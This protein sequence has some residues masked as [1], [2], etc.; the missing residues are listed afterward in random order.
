MI[1]KSKKHKNSIR[2]VPKV[3]KQKA[4]DLYEK[5]GLLNE[6]LLFSEGLLR[7]RFMREQILK[8]MDK[9]CDW[10]IRKFNKEDAKIQSRI[11]VHHREYMQHCT[12][13]KTLPTSDKDIWRSI[14]EG[15]ECI[16]VPD[17]R[18]CYL[19]YVRQGDKRFWRCFDLLKPLHAECHKAVH[20]KEQ[21]GHTRV[22]RLGFQK[23]FHAGADKLPQAD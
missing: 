6:W 2:N 1:E 20:A 13:L 19:R 11:E 9:T 15:E 7:N 3:R 5:Q 10:C 16:E 4:R 18:S 8:R 12:F 17:C 14:G 22:K 23:A 21:E